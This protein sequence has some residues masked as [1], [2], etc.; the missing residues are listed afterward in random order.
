MKDL[1]NYKA[2][3]LLHNIRDKTQD[4]VEIYSRNEL[5]KSKEESK[6]VRTRRIFDI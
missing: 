6:K 5:E 1:K 4:V 2:Y 3:S